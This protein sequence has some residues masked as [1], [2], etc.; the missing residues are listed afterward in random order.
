VL[1]ILKIA[2]F[3][4]HFHWGLFLYKKIQKNFTAI[5]RTAYAIISNFEQETQR[6]LSNRNRVHNNRWTQWQYTNSSTDRRTLHQCHKLFKGDTYD[7][8][9]SKEEVCLKWLLSASRWPD[10]DTFLVTGWTTSWVDMTPR[11]S[12]LFLT[13]EPG[14]LTFMTSCDGLNKNSEKQT[15]VTSQFKVQVSCHPTTGSDAAHLFQQRRG[16]DGIL[17]VNWVLQCLGQSCGYLISSQH[18]G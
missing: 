7:C 11:K 16:D 1:L 17:T 3:H 13:S 18:L 10:R 14:G 12:L 9:L 8:S 4:L 6:K 2:N 15:W 5:P